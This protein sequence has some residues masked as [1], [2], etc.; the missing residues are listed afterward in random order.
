M[1]DDKGSVISQIM[2]TSIEIDTHLE[3]TADGDLDGREYYHWVQREPGKVKTG[4]EESE[5]S[6]KA[7]PRLSNQT[8]YTDARRHGGTSCQSFRAHG[9][10][11]FSLSLYRKQWLGFG[12]GRRVAHGSG[13]RVRPGG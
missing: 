4:T 7:C 2:F 10:F 12:N 5:W 9:W 6:C 13:Q 3:E 1:L 11:G 8:P